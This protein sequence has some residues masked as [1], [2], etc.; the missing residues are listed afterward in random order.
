MLWVR[1]LTGPLLTVPSLDWTLAGLWACV[2]LVPPES[3]GRSSTHTLMD[4]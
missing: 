3:K 1:P 2:G 4:P